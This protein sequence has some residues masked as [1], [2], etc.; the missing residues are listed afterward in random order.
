MKTLLKDKTTW[1]TLAV[2]AT[3]LVLAY[4]T[5]SA[6]VMLSAAGEGLMAWG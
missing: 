1:I 5:C 2:I 6:N 3:S 4:S